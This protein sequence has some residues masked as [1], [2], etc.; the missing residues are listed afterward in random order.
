MSLAFQQ[1]MATIRT[2]RTIWQPLLS[3][4][5][6]FPT[7]DRPLQPRRLT[8]QSYHQA[9]TYTPA[10]SPAAQ[11][12]PP[13]ADPQVASHSAP[14][15][16]LQ[17]ASRSAPAA[18]R[19]V[20]SHSAPA[21]DLQAASH[22]APAADLQAASY[23]APDA[24]PQV[25]SSATNHLAS[26]LPSLCDMDKQDMPKLDPANYGPWL[27]ALRSAA[28]TTEASQHI[29]GTPPLRLMP[30]PS[31]HIKKEALYLGEDTVICPIGNTCSAVD[32]LANEGVNLAMRESGMSSHHQG[33]R[34]PLS[35]VA[36]RK[37]VDRR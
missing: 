7:T 11:Q 16:D 36:Q 30:T 13:A 31:H 9:L 25:P 5:P 29:T 24:D 22:S 6:P 18:D 1:V 8:R 21:A 15:A 37:R 33:V 35:V 28:Y 10:A 3:A 14:A 20:A 27:L 17:V 34:D 2:M 32:T 23:S 26:A 4:H 19:Q 12:P